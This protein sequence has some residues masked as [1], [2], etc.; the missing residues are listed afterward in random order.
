MKEINHIPNTEDEILVDVHGSCVSRNI[1]N[2]NIFENSK[3]KVN[4]HF[5]RNC[6]IS[7]MMPPV[8]FNVE[9]SEMLHKSDYSYRCMRYALHKNTV[10]LLEKSTS[11]FLVIDFF[12]LCQNAVAYK[13]TTFSHYDTSFFAT[14]AYKENVDKYKIVHFFDMPMFLWFGYID[15]Y[16]N[17]MTEKF[18]DNIILVRLQCAK[19]YIGKNV[20]SG[21]V[22]KDFPEWKLGYGNALYN[23]KLKELEDCIIE[24]YNPYVI[25]VSKYFISDES[26]NADF[27]PVHFENDYALAASKS[28][29][30][31]IKK[32]PKQKYYENIDASIVSRILGR[33]I[34]EPDFIKIYHS[35]AVPF[36]SCEL[37]DEITLL[38]SENDIIKNRK[39]LSLLYESFYNICSDN[40]SVDSCG[41]FLDYTKKLSNSRDFCVEY[42]EQ[43]NNKF[44][45]L[46]MDA[47]C[48]LSLFEEALNENDLIWMTI[49]SCLRI[50]EPNN[51][52]VI[53]YSKAYY[54]M[55]NDVNKVKIYEQKY[56]GV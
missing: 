52:K 14:S 29:Y 10:P 35:S 9:Q 39:W 44:N 3:I 26:H 1:F 55:K 48:L 42:L 18:G 28:M 6:V 2:V 21:G 34:S 12:D 15:L 54:S 31:I 19:Y 46:N 16:L 53:L 49:L 40:V 4:Q 41:K 24:K 23:E 37:L 30:E 38:F 11:Q 27:T 5:S 25:D 56:E 22:V 47:D 51:E 32:K 50:L 8:D 36:N 43:L 45:F 7:S 20:P 13:N 33:N 17:K